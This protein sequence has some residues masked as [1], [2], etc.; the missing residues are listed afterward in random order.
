MGMTERFGGIWFE[1]KFTSKI[2]VSEEYDSTLDAISSIYQRTTDGHYEVAFWLK[3]KAASDPQWSLPLW[4][5]IAGQGI[6]GTIDD[7][8]SHLRAIRDQHA[9]VSGG[10]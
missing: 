10:A 3:G 6:F 1:Q 5:S 7:A 9:S 8:I 2:L 4:G